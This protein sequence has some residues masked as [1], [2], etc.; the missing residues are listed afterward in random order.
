MPNPST[1][2]SE[3][4][5][6]YDRALQLFNNPRLAKFTREQ[7]LREARRLAAELGIDGPPPVNGRPAQR[8]LNEP[9]FTFSSDE[10]EVLVAALSCWRGDYS[11]TAEQADIAAALERRLTK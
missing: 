4:E 5:Q 9:I 3:L 8:Q 10:R 7:A 1:E 6:Q 11:R 2:Q